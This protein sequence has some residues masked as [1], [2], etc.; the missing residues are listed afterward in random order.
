MTKRLSIIVE[1][2]SNHAELLASYLRRLQFEV[3][4]VLTI[5]DAV[6]LCR[7]LLSSSQPMRQTFI[8]ID[9]QLLLHGHVD[10]E[11]S[12]LAL[13]LSEE[14]KLGLL[15]PTYL[16]AISADMTPKRQAL[17]EEAGCI[18]QLE[19]PILQKHITSLQ[20]YFDVV[21]VVTKAPSTAVHGLTTS[22]LEL[23]KAV[24]TQEPRDRTWSGYEVELVIGLLSEAFRL[25][26]DQQSQAQYLVSW[27]GGPSR[28]AIL[29]RKSLE[30]LT[31]ERQEILQR[32]LRKEQQKN[33]QADMG[34]GRTKFENEFRAICNLV[35][36]FWSDTTEQVTTE[37][38]RS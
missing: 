4:I 8:F 36:A 12:T 37:S 29:L 13:L 38:S 10:V 15:H 23:L 33:I 21:P 30:V 22:T 26:A 31:D 27:L 2:N 34:I 1:D 32:L 3:H 25:N 28:T 9:Q 17:A 7:T 5:L 18:A 24:I 20:P 14:M 11:G 35:A 16:I 19:K 6:H